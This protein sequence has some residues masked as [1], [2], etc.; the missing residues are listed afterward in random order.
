MDRLEFSSAF[1]L[2]FKKKTKL[3]ENI[4]VFNNE[5][6]TTRLMDFTEGFQLKSPVHMILA[7]ISLKDHTEDQKQYICNTS[8]N[9]R[10]KKRNKSVKRERPSESLQ[11]AIHVQVLEIMLF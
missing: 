9:C 5:L 6:P 2:K 3:K 4:N 8:F 10:K 7:K 1:G 11:R